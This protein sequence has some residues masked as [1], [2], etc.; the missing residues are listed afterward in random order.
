VAA[1]AVI[2]GMDPTVMAATPLNPGF[3]NLA[4]DGATG[5]LIFAGM[6]YGLQF[7]AGGG[8]FVGGLYAA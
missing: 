1:Y 5:Y 7:G 2:F 8:V 4:I 3:L 6:N